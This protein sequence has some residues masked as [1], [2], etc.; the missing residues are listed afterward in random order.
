MTVLAWNARNILEVGGRRPSSGGGSSGFNWSSHT[1]SSAL[2]L[3]Y[4]EHNHRTQ[5]ENALKGEGTC[6]EKFA[7]EQTH[8]KPTHSDPPELN[9]SIRLLC[10][11]R[12]TLATASL[13][14]LVHLWVIRKRAHT[15]TQEHTWCKVCRYMD[16]RETSLHKKWCIASPAANKDIGFAG[17]DQGI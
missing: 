5:L 7:E 11:T 9:A 6:H 12:W 10:S 4:T 13:E 15:H 14:P 2:Q 1:T 17:C 16:L 3:G 8:T